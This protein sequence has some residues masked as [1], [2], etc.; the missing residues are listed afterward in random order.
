MASALKNLSAYDESSLPSA[1]GMRFGIVVAEW[2]ARITHA[3]YEGCYDTL[4]KHGAQASDIYTVQVPG[5]FELPAGA[6]LLAGKQKLDAVIC[7]GCVIKGETSHNEYINHA[8]AT[9]LTNLSIASGQPF[10]FGVLTPDNEAQAL[11]RAGGKHGNK[12]VEAAT[13]A[14]RMAALKKELTD[15]TKIGF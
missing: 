15:K 7:L 13:T 5:S 6:R 12:G 9:G 11:D 1:D 2:N 8:V 10:I 14:I 3:L 4:L